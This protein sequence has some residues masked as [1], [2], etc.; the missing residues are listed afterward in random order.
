[1]EV[2]KFKCRNCGS[3]SAEKI[4]D[5]TYR[6]NYCGNE[7]KIIIKQEEKVKEESQEKKQE[8]KQENIFQ[9]TVEKF[10]SMEKGKQKSLIMFLL[11]LLVGIFGVHKF[12]EGKIL[13]GLIY[14]FTGGFFVVGW[15]IDTCI[16]AKNILN[17]EDNDGK[18]N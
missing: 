14:F 18:E 17:L 15:L 10:N 6:C 12:I 13:A 1:M 16:Y 7:E 4:D 2:Y 8:E 9:K 3:T 11:C 5:S